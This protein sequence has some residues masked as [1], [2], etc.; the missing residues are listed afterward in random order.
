MRQKEVARVDRVLTGRGQDTN[1][2]RKPYEDRHKA[3]STAKERDF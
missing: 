2:L 3:V 1:Q